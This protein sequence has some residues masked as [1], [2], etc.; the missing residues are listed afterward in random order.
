MNWK[1][2][3]G[4]KISSPIK[5]LH[6]ML[7]YHIVSFITF[8]HSNKVT[9]KTINSNLPTDTLLVEARILGLSWP[10]SKNTVARTASVF[11][12]PGRLKCSIS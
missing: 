5:S 6:S 10:Y 7:D 4:W 12:M 8:K 1:T 3:S 11:I 9:S 2:L